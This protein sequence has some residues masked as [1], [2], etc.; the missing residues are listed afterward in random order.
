MDIQSFCNDVVNFDCLCSRL[1]SLQQ[2][3]EKKR[4]DFPKVAF[5][6]PLTDSSRCAV[7]EDKDSSTVSKIRQSL[8]SARDSAQNR[9]SSQDMNVKSEVATIAKLW[10]ENKDLEEKYKKDYDSSC[11]CLDDAF[12]VLCRDVEVVSRLFR[13]V[14]VL[15]KALVA[16]DVKVV[17]PDLFALLQ[18]CDYLSVSPVSQR[19][20]KQACGS[21]SK[22]VDRPSPSSS[23]TSSAGGSGD[24]KESYIV[25]LS[26]EVKAL[27]K[28]VEDQDSQLKDLEKQKAFVSSY[29]EATIAS[30][31]NVISLLRTELQ[32]RNIPD[33]TVKKE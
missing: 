28:I 22:A 21:G 33:P 13:I 2:Q 18:H 7:P 1:S 14:K 19:V 31:N 24:D 16:D 27:R 5:V 15:E 3:L 4:S 23:A 9:V 6:P 25:A 30:L 17:Y 11:G 8:K 20:L 29:A 26:E 10:K 32:S 12:K